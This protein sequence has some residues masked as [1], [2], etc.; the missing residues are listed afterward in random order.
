ME[1]KTL[2]KKKAKK[3]ENKAEEKIIPEQ[4]MALH[5]LQKQ[6]QVLELKE[7]LVSIG[8]IGIVSLLR[9]PMQVIPNAEP[10]TFFAILAGWLFG[11]KKGVFVGISSL[12]LSNFL[13]LGGQGPWTIFQAAG[14]ALVGFLGGMLR[15]K[16]SFFE[17]LMIVLISTISLQLIFNIGWSAMM[18]MSFFIAM[19]TGLIFTAIHIISNLAFATLLPAARKFIY[20][21]FGF[22]EKE[23]CNDLIAELNGRMRAKQRDSG[24]QPTVQ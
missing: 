10:L 12:Y 3:Q 9:V 13:V 1:L 14:Y 24:K 22:N 7:W 5:A 21:K 2:L 8:F 17:V 20:E 6:K 16:A 4:R 18:G 23:L 11:R 15:E 19:M